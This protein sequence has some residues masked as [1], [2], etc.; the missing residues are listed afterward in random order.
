VTTTRVAL[1][2]LAGCGLILAPPINAAAA[3]Q[4]ASAGPAQPLAADTP[5]ATVAGHTFIAPAGWS[6]TVKGKA[7]IVEAPEGDSRIVFV[8]VTAMEADAAIQEAWAAYQPNAKW[9]LKSKTASS[10]KDGWTHQQTY[11]YQTSPNER[12]SVAAG[13]AR[14]DDQHLV[15]IYDMSDPVAEKRGAQVALIFGRLFPKGYT[16]E[17]FA[18]RKA[19][20]L[21]AARIA[22][23]GAFIERG[24][25]QL[26]VPGVS[27]AIVQGG[28]VVFG[29]G[30]GVRELGNPEKPDA[31]TLY[32][33]AS[34]T[35]AMTTML[36]GRLVDQKKITWQTPVTKI[37]PQFKLGDP[38][39][40]SK[41]LVEHLICACT[42]LPRQ[43]FEWLLEFGKATPESALATLGTMQPTS[44][45][46][47]MFQYSNP[48]AAAGGY[49]GAHVLFPGLELGAA[50]DRAMAAEVFGPLG[51][52]ST[53]FDFARALGANHASAHALDIDGKPAL[54]AMDVNYSIV[55]VRPAGGAWSSVKDVLK[56]VQMELAMGVLPD[57]TRYV[58]EVVLKERREPKVW[59]GKD[60]WYGMGLQVDKTYGTPVVHHGGSMIGYKSD[61]LW[62]PEHGVGA[63][64][65]TNGD[66]GWA[67]SGNFRRKLLEVLFDGKPE[68]DNDLAAAAKAMKEYIAA[69]RKLLTVP[70]DPAEV[71]KLASSYANASLGEILVSK[72]HKTV[73][74]FGEF[75]SEV[76]SRLNPDGS[77]SFLTTIPGFDG[78]EFVVGGAADKRT[79]VFRDAQ[80]EYTFTE[81]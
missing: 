14:H 49:V 44:K 59:I 17:T 8:D 47:E 7:T 36:L 48:L 42:G 27:L 1:L 9:P 65:L 24:Q 26:G 50:Y 74:D 64:V 79:L 6:L 55:P 20:S 23:L 71:A 41:V 76:A 78:L 45:F 61:M 29:G 80:H 62:L 38:E 60:D 70:P 81:K 67:I 39:T 37:L 28:K 68:A 35:K 63:V 32:I 66:P 34:N 75:K 69:E 43:D 22:E 19:N 46:G 72:G 58:S 33:I 18:G 16:R 54:A 57:G 40:T 11:A 51:M 5:S 73:F 30:F 4:E 15:W 52:A 31:D 21:N 77:V 2:I 25:S 13:T 12:R 10:D 3:P 56:Y 53:T